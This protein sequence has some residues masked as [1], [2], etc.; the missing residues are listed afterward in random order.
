MLAL[1]VGQQQIAHMT[2]DR[3]DKIAGAV[4]ARC[5]FTSSSCTY[6]CDHLA[7]VIPFSLAFCL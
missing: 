4:Q 2:I 7:M 1:D 3:G 5:F 6:D